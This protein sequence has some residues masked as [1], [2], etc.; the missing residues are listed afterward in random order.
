MMLMNGETCKR[1]ECAGASKMSPK[2][3]RKSSNESPGHDV[4]N[5]S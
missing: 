2:R 4:I 1:S 5:M 3:V